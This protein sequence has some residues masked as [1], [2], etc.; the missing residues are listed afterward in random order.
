MGL[1]VKHIVSED[2]IYTFD[3]TI[4]DVYWVYVYFRSEQVN[5][6]MKLG[7]HLVGH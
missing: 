2:N 4:M 1:E 6:S 7:K 3:I 5:V